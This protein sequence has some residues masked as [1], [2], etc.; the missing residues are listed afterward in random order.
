MTLSIGKYC[1]GAGFGV[2]G[3]AAVVMVIPGCAVVTEAF[4]TSDCSARTA[5][6]SWPHPGLVELPNVVDATPCGRG[7]P[8][9]VSVMSGA[10]WMSKCLSSS[11]VVSVSRMWCAPGVSV[12]SGVAARMSSCQRACRGVI[13]SDE[14]RGTRSSLIGVESVGPVSQ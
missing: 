8:R 10:Q 3:A 11:P 14:D 13:A 7:L 9:L 4:G 2:R 6:D 5:A 1:A 12:F